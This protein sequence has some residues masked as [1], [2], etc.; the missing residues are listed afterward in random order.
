MKNL[1]QW[2]MLSRRNA[3][4][5]AAICLT[6][7]FLFW[8]GAALLALTILRQGL[9]SSRP[10]LGWAL[11]PAI[12]W[13]SLG[14]PMPL[15]AAS[16]A[17]ILAVVL[18]QTV[19][20]DRTMF[21]AAAIGGGIYVLLPLLMPEVLALILTSAEQVVDQAL[22]Q[23]P[24]VLSEYKPHIQ[25]M[26]QGFLAAIYLLVI[27]LSLLLGRYWQSVLYNPNGF[28]LEFKQF[29]LP[30]AYSVITMLLL[31][32]ATALTPELAGVTPVLTVP[33]MLAG[34]ALLHKL[35]SSKAG[36]GWMVPVYIA[37]FLFGPYMYTLLIF[38]AFF[39]SL[40][41]FRARLKDTA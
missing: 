21:V 35:A 7:P 16:G 23:Q 30:A 10:V 31:L 34:L 14:D 20:L 36:S 22:A 39:D 33:M 17:S 5:A 4:L 28:G 2:A 27:I 29:M 15:V 1:A 26:I 40:F 32:G 37:L 9:E 41:N 3:T 6:I 25:A 12:L 13:L 11:L 38:L 18:R 8:L 24:Q 19:R